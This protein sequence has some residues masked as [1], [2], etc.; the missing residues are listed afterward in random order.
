VR[1]VANSLSGPFDPASAQP[2]EESGALKNAEVC[3]I[4]GD[5][6]DCTSTRPLQC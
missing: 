2:H 5:L 3:R 6:V 4:A 1:P